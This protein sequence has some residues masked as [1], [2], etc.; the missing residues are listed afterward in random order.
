M[1]VFN[2]IYPCS[3]LSKLPTVYQTTVP[4]V[5]KI[6]V[7][8]HFAT[9]LVDEKQENAT[10]YE[11]VCRVAKQTVWGIGIGLFYPIMFPV[12]VYRSYN[13]LHNQHRK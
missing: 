1:F 10:V 13:I 6:V 8:Y 11:T 4:I 12:L 3:F 7:P 2:T 5:M 9:A